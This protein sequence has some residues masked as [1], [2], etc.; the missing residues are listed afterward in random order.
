MDCAKHVSIPPIVNND[1]DYRARISVF[2]PFTMMRIDM[3]SSQHSSIRSR[4]LNTSPLKIFAL[5]RSSCM[6]HIVDR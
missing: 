4:L 2:L 3:N 5:V 6:V 1:R